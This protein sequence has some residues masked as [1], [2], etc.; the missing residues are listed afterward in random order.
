MIHR[1]GGAAHDVEA[2]RAVG[3][4]A[5]DE[6]SHERRDVELPGVDADLAPA[7]IA[8]GDREPG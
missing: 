5:N 3:V 1:V 2:E 8:D 6:R 7:C 4:D